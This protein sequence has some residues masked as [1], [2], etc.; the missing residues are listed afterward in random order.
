MTARGRIYL[1][2]AVFSALEPAGS[3][4]V[5]CVPLFRC[6]SALAPK[7]SA[8]SVMSLIGTI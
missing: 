7:G 3:V 8:L 6:V 5:S 2:D 1:S 4:F